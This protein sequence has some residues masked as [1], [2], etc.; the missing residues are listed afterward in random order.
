VLD[1]LPAG[2][3]PITTEIARDA[4][5]RKR[6]YDLIRTEAEAGRRAF[7]VCALVDESNALEAK[8]AVAEAERLQ[9]EV[10]PN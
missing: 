2:R 8:A 3:Q 7:V 6:A 10:S 9:T 4:G 1:E 5:S